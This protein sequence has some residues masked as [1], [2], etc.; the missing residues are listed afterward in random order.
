LD[1]ADFHRRFAEEAPDGL[2][3]VDRNGVIRFWNGGCERI[4]G[5]LAAEAVGMPLDIIIPERLRARHGQGF[6]ETMR[7]GRT[8]YGAGELLSV[9]ALR[10]DQARISVEFSIV[11]FR[12]EDGAMAGVGAIMRDVTQRFDEMKALRESVR[13]GTRQQP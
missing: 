11:P 3:A 10:K 1:I 8:R 6:A 7:T 5:F 4:F 13:S 12:G 9:P 2:L